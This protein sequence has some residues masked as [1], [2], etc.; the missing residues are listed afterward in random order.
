M[1][2][3]NQNVENAKSIAQLT[4][5]DVPIS[6]IDPTDWY[7]GL[8]N[9]SLQLMVYGEGIRDAEVS[10][11]GAKIDSLVRLDS[12]NYL[13]VYL[14]VKGCKAG[15]LPLT[16]TL[17]EKQ[18]TIAY[19]LNQRNPH[20][21]KYLIQNSIWWI[22]TI[23]INGIRM[24]TYPYADRI[25]MA[26]WMRVLGEETDGWWHGYNRIYNSLVY[27][28]LYE[29]PSNVMAFIENHDTDQL[30]REAKDVVTGQKYDLTKDLTLAP[31]QTLIVEF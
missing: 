21:L 29:K 5:N 6:R 15:T 28:Y 1:T 7:V 4:E 3:C 18:T 13:L 17:G 19:E 23:G 27:D 10:V 8:K 31:R 2:A 16:F 11:S 24:D 22:E 9:P 14:N 20:V 25:A 30:Q 26:E 12:P